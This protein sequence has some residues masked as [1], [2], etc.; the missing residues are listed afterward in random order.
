M[1]Q[2]AGPRLVPGRGA[3]TFEGACPRPLTRPSASASNP[4]D[5]RF[6]SDVMGRQLLLVGYGMNDPNMRWTWTKL[7]DLEVP[8]VGWLLEPGASTDLER[9]TMEM[10]R[11]TRL[12]LQAE[13][14]DRPRELLELPEA[15]A[16]RCE[17]E[18]TPPSR[19]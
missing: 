19:R 3:P 16:D 7:R 4:I 8:L 1:I 12:D 18:L 5:L 11:I 15:L 2:R 14:P 10:D 6:C 17:R 9:A 13:D